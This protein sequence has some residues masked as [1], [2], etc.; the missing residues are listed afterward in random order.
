MT[1]T[2]RTNIF[3][4]PTVVFSVPGT[5]TGEPPVEVAR[6]TETGAERI[7]EDDQTRILE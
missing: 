1:M 2:C 7:T 4:V 3:C 5:G 6:L